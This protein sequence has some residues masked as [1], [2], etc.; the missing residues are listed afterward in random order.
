MS[1]KP[2]SLYKS[3]AESNF[4]GTDIEIWAGFGPV[5]STEIQIGEGADYE[6]L[7][8]VVFSCFH[9]QKIELSLFVQPTIQ[10]AFLAYFDP[11][12]YILKQ[13]FTV[14]FTFMLINFLVRTL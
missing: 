10:Y 7:L 5:G 11:E 6:K 3:H 9:R 1:L 14:L 4:Y 13:K 2:K 12:K 8:R